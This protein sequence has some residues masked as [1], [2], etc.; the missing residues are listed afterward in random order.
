MGKI[1]KLQADTNILV[2][3]FSS[4]YQCLCYNR[5]QLAM[6]YLDPAFT[7]LTKALNEIIQENTSKWRYNRTAFTEH[8]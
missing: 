8:R 6:K 2:Q 1:D 4:V 3:A 5:S 7:P